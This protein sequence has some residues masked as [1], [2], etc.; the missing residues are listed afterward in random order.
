M[1]S[2]NNLSCKMRT[3]IYRSRATYRVRLPGG[4]WRQVEWRETSPLEHEPAL[5]REFA[6]LE[7]TEEAILGFANQHGQPIPAEDWQ[8]SIAAEYRQFD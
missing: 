8:D 7:L 1:R 2:A 5:F 4:E 6:D 3:R